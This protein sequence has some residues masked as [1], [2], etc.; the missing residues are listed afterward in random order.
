MLDVEVRMS[1]NGGERALL[2]QCAA[3][4][5]VD[6]LRRASAQRDLGRVDEQFPSGADR[7]V[8]HTVFMAGWMNARILQLAGEHRNECARGLCRSCH[9]S[10]TC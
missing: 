5:G 6:S 2:H 9:T 3:V 4:Y 7:S 1:A 8:M 10:R